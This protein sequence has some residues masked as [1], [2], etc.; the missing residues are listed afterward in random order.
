MTIVH[1]EAANFIKSKCG[2]N[3]PKIMI[4]CG[5]GLGP[6]SNELKNRTMISYKDIPNYPST[7][8]LGHKG[9]LAIGQL[10]GIWVICAL[11]RFHYYE[12]NSMDIV[13]FPVRVAYR[14]GIELLIVTNAAGGLQDRKHKGF[15]V[16]DVMQI[17]DHVALPC[18]SGNHPLR[19]PNIDVGPRFVPMDNAYDKSLIKK[20][21]AIIKSLNYEN[22]FK[23][24]V[25]CMVSGSYP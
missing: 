13:A 19:G 20:C 23:K 4:I 22:S 7:T 5:T 14:I 6:L 17:T 18:L 3:V 25:Y 10:N 21:D 16:G 1:Q 8:I 24:G 15:S 9:E 11:G 12:G 2:K